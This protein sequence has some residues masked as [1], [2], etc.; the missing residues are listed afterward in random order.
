MANDSPSTLS[1]F[2][3]RATVILGFSSL[4]LSTALRAHVVSVPPPWE[5]VGRSALAVAVIGLVIVL[6]LRTIAR[7]W[8]AATIAAAVWLGLFA[9]YPALAPT[10]R[11]TDGYWVACVY[12]AVCCVLAGLVARID[13]SRASRIVRAA[14][15]MSIVGVVVGLLQIAPA[16]A[17]SSPS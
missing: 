15:V 7:S 13:S 17:R 10:S 1:R 3:V 16:Y 2:L 14:S 6:A 9:A 11:A 4:P 12:L 8:D 5:S